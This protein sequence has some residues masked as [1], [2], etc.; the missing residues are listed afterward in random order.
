MFATIISFLGIPPPYPLDGQD[1]L[2]IVRGERHKVRDYLTCGHTAYVRAV[3]DEYALIAL[4]TGDEPRLHDLKNDPEEKVNLAKER[5]QTVKRMFD[6]V[7]EDAGRQP[8]LPNWESSVAFH[9]A[10]SF[11]DYL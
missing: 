5:P 10:L 11:R 9:T 1:L 6:Y 8:I 2:P 3:D 4:R 7:M